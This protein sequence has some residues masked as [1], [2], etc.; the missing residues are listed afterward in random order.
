MRPRYAIVLALAAA[1]SGGGDAG[2][3]EN[4]PTRPLSFGPFNMP[5]SMRQ[6]RSG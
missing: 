5:P 1:G 4:W 3:A 2:A 6:L